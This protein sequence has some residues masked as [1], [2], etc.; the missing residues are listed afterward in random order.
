M[1]LLKAAKTR[2]KR[3]VKARES[4]GRLSWPQPSVVPSSGIGFAVRLALHIL[5]A[6]AHIKDIEESLGHAPSLVNAAVQVGRA[7]LK[8]N[9]KRTY[10]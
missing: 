10:T 9:V 3:P 1:L 4:W 8:P 5:K 6:P 7:C 2:S